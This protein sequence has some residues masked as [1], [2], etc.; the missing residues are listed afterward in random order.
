MCD[1]PKTISRGKETQYCRTVKLKK[2]SGTIG[3]EEAGLLVKE[4]LCAKF[5]SLDCKAGFS[6]ECCTLIACGFSAWHR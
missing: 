6:V 5:G 3:E 4:G 2:K 1:S